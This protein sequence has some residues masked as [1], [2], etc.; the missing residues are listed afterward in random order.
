M[1][2]GPQLRS[3]LPP[4]TESKHGDV[5]ADVRGTHRPGGG[6]GGVVQLDPHGSESTLLV[7]FRLKA[8]PLVPVKMNCFH[9][10][11]A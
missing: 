8:V 4:R 1:S 6:H 3:L 7:W 9:R 11:G 10:K 2:A 5:K